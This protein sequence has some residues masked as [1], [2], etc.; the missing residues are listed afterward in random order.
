MI[1]AE[2]IPKDLPTYLAAIQAALI[3]IVAVPVGLITYIGQRD[4]STRAIELYYRESLAHEVFSSS[5]ALLV[6]LTVQLF[7]PAQLLLHYFVPYPI[8]EIDFGWIHAA[9]L[10][11]NLVVVAH[12]ITTSLRYV[13]PRARQSIRRSYIVNRA[14]PFQLRHQL[15]RYYYFNSTAELLPHQSRGGLSYLTILFGR[16]AAVEGAKEELVKTFKAATV[17]YDLHLRILGLAVRPWCA[18]SMQSAQLRRAGGGRSAPF[19]G[20]LPDL[21][22]PLRGRT[23][24]CVSNRSAPLRWREKQIIRMAFRL[25]RPGLPKRTQISP[26][27]LLDDLIGH[28]IAAIDRSAES[29]YDRAIDEILDFHG[30]LL[31]VYATIDPNGEAG[32]FAQVP[33]DIQTPQQE[34]IRPYYRLSQKAVSKISED[35]SYARAVANVPFRLLLARPQTSARWVATELLN[36]SAYFVHRLE[37]WLTEHRRLRSEASEGTLGTMDLAGSDVR[38]YTAV[39]RHFVGTWRDTLKMSDELMRWHIDQ[40]AAPEIR[41]QQFARSWWY[42]ETHL[43][44]SGYLVGAAVRNDDSRGATAYLDTLLKWLNY[45]PI[46][47]RHDALFAPEAMLFPEIIELPWAEAQV[48]AQIASPW[49]EQQ[50]DPIALA[51]QLLFIE[52]DDVLLLTGSVFVSWCLHAGQSSELVARVVHNIF[53]RHSDFEESGLSLGALLNPPSFWHLLL[54]ILRIMSNSANPAGNAYGAR[55]DRLVH[56]LDSLREP[57]VV[58]GEI[59]SPG[60]VFGQHGLRSAFLCVLLARISDV[61]RRKSASSNQPSTIDLTK[62]PDVQADS[63][64]LS[65]ALNQLQQELSDAPLAARLRPGVHAI[66][67]DQALDDAIAR[68]K[69]VLEGVVGS[70]ETAREEWLRSAPIATAR[71]R[72]I[73]VAIRQYV[74]TN[75][76]AECILSTVP[77]FLSDPANED[78]IETRFITGQI[79]GQLVELPL[80]PKVSGFDSAIAQQVNTLLMRSIWHH[81]FGRPRK[82][83]NAGVSIT[84]LSFWVQAVRHAEGVGSRPFALLSAGDITAVFQELLGSRAQDTGALTFQRRNPERSKSDKGYRFSVDDMDVY[85]VD[86]QPGTIFIASEQKLASLELRLVPGSTA[87]FTVGFVPS[88]DPHGEALKIQWAARV[89]WANTPVIELQAATA[90]SA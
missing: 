68:L 62:I 64:G 8:F 46:R 13:D 32:S 31:D 61:D 14:L 35:T 10:V 18:R 25:R 33:G 16:H 67:P 55:L 11:A 30:F 23:A 50:Y 57:D 5:L 41:W 6:V 56:R 70:L 26:A 52:H 79:K 43:F 77:V 83:I 85:V 48:K 90:K 82:Q 88:G 58:P 34:W 81:F 63:F 4:D 22:L 27:D 36:F 78:E 40:T 3:V 7:W 42:L 76:N 69:Q 2:A 49:P 74:G 24:W 80:E 44:N 75:F 20:F 72:E 9:W 17:L 15:L 59:Y 28:A 19:M 65:A 54:Q 73:E 87:Q 84:S 39:I 12:F 37:N 1:D 21:D 60:T 38:G 71:L 53:A 66:N 86:I 89:V 51:D 47:E 45:L 29:A